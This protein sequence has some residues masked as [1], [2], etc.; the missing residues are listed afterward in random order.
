MLLT[1]IAAVNA[2]LLLAALAVAQAGQD[3]TD[4]P[5]GADK[6]RQAVEAW[7]K[8]LNNGQPLPVPPT[9]A[10][11]DDDAVRTLFPDGR[12]YTVRFMRFP[13]AVIPPN[14]LKL[15]NLVRVRPD[16][17]VDRIESLDALKK[18]CEAKLADVRDEGKA[19]V[20]L[21]ACLRLAEEFYQDGYYTFTVPERSVSVVRRDNHWVASGKAEVTKGGKG[22]I[23]VTVTTGTPSTVTIGGKVRP[24]VRDR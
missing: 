4:P 20:A 3:G 24:D 8:D 23:T 16:G 2:G 21:L 6:G 7:L 1:K 14:R 9:I 11:A 19:R 18:L 15:E 5:A 22:E 17:S 13:R 12:F 10:A